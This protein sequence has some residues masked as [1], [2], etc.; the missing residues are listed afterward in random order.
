MELQSTSDPNVL[1][2]REVIALP[3]LGGVDRELVDRAVDR[4]QSEQA[5]VGNAAI[6]FHGLGDRGG[7]GASH[8][9]TKGASSASGED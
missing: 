8:P 4:P 6:L 2:L 9:A 3:F 7:I 1:R 5:N